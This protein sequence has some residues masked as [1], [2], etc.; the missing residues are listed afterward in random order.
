[1]ISQA[2]LSHVPWTF[3][4][5]ATGFYRLG[6]YCVSK[7]PTAPV[8]LSVSCKF[9]EDCKCGKN[10]LV[11]LG[12]FDFRRAEDLRGV[13]IYLGNLPHTSSEAGKEHGAAVNSLNLFFLLS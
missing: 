5:I 7:Y 3:L 13:Q 8:S 11:I 9:A 6:Y 2:S 4:A 12:T 10:C 1:M